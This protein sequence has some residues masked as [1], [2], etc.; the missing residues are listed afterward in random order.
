MDDFGIT[1]HSRGGP[2]AAARIIP[3]L[4]RALLTVARLTL[5]A[6]NDDI[7]AGG[8]LTLAVLE[9]QDGGSS[10]AFPPEFRRVLGALRHLVL[11][12]GAL[13]EKQ[14]VPC[15][16]G[17]DPRTVADYVLEAER[18]ATPATEEPR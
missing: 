18:A 9:S 4:R 14:P 8:P 6:L 5:E 1:F 13:S 17:W 12:L 7:R 2:D 11:A 10:P 15:L 16:G 3:D